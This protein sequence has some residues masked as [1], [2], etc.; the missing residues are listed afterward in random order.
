MEVGLYGDLLLLMS[1]VLEV[2]GRTT[3]DSDDRK[4]AIVS[5]PARERP[6]D[7]GGLLDSI[8]ALPR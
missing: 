6:L 3:C 1:L 2:I 7:G 5:E 4:E 8:E